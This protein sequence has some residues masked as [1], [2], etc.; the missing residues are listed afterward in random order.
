MRRL[1]LSALALAAAATLGCASAGFTP[2][3]PTMPAARQALRPEYRIFYDALTDYGDWVLIEPYGFVFH[4]K[5]DYASWRPYSY[6]FWAPSDTWGWVWISG[7]PF[8]WAT[9]HYGSWLFDRFQ[10]WVWMPGVDWGLTA[11][12]LSA[13]VVPPAEAAPIAASARPV[14]NIVERDGVRFPFGPPFERVE[15]AIGRPLTRVSIQELIAA[16]GAAASG[17]TRAGRGDHPA[18]PPPADAAAA[19]IETMRR[20]GEDAARRVREAIANKAAAPAR[21]PVVRPPWIR[22]VEDETRG[23]GAAPDTTR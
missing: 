10:G 6:G 13:H 21:V 22:R 7:E 15:R 4:P 17:Q 9:Y 23:P 16:G 12:D 3:T 18:A 2:Q 20:A 11:T 5:V 8:G 1:A 19:R 14:E